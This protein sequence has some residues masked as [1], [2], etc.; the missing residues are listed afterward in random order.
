VDTYEKLVVSPYHTLPVRDFEIPNL[1]FAGNV[2]LKL[3]GLKN[4][5]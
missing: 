3:G 1:S 2:N 5:K 4:E